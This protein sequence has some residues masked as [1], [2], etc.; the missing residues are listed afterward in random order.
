MYFERKLVENRTLKF[1]EILWEH[2][3]YDYYF[4]LHNNFA[5]E[6]I[7]NEFVFGINK[8]REKK[9]SIKQ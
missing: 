9:Q 1:C 8:K 4:E 6:Y 3:Y 2:M 5:I 7:I